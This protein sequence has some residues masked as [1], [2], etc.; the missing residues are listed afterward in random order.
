MKLKTILLINTSNQIW[1]N[2]CQNFYNNFNFSEDFADSKKIKNSLNILNGRN[3]LEEVRYGNVGN[4][5]DTIENCMNF[6][7]NLKRLKNPKFFCNNH[8]KKKVFS[9]IKFRLEKK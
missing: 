7:I 5:M 9:L 3:S 6:S 8:K 4:S 1:K 2:L